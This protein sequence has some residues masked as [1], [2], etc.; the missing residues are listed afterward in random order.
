M[1]LSFAGRL[2]VTPS[3]GKKQSW[4]L[5]MRGDKK[6]VKLLLPKLQARL[7]PEGSA[8]A[9]GLPLWHCPQCGAAVT[10]HPDSCA[11]CRAI[12][13]SSRMATLLSLAFPGAGLLYVC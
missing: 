9:Q 11:S 2:M 6:L 4:R 12:F 10:P 8:Q 3:Q 1:K 5:R 7:L 13:R